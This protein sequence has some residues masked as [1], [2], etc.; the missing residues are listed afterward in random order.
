M[1]QWV[2]MN[3]NHTLTG[4]GP[5]FYGLRPVCFDGGKFYL[6]PAGSSA[7]LILTKCNYQ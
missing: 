1:L 2:F 3:D 7:N 5:E 4:L 6:H